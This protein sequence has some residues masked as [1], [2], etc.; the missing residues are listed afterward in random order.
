MQARVHLYMS[1]RCLSL[2]LFCV[3]DVYTPI[4]IIGIVKSVHIHDDVNITMKWLHMCIVW[5][6]KVNTWLCCNSIM[7]WNLY[8]QK[9]TGMI[10]I[11]KCCR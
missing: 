3:G 9:R 8:T 6:H 11:W 1:P 7:K 10:I 5:C 2:A 4:T